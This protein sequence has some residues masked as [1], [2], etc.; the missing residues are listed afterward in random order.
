MES[1]SWPEHIH[2]ASFVR[3]RLWV[4]ADAACSPN[5]QGAGNQAKQTTTDKAT[6][7]RMS[8]RKDGWEISMCYMLHAW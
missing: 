6:V 2:I 1:S 3:D 8:N 4:S 7:F 5:M